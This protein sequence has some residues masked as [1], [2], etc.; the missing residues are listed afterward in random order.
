[1][2]EPRF[3]IDHGVIH[4]R[5]TGKHVRTVGNVEGSGEDG[6]E[7]CCALLNELDAPDA[8]RYHQT[9]GAKWMVE[10]IIRECRTKFAQNRNAQEFANDL[11]RRWEDQSFWRPLPP[12][13]GH[14]Q[15][16]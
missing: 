8:N 12:S 13:T 5:K 7:E 6:I 16:K 3:F 11:E 2:S 1:M 14:G 10:A 4:D 15:E 9:L